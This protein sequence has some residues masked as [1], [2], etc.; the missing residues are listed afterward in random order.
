MGTTA[1]GEAELII[2]SEVLRK[3]R[4]GSAKVKP[5]D[6]WRPSTMKMLKAIADLSKSWI[7]NPRGSENSYRKEKLKT[8][9][10]DG[11]GGSD[12]GFGDS[13]GTVFTSANAGI[14]TPTYG[15]RKT[16]K[17]RQAKEKSGIERLDDFV[18]DNS[19]ERK[20]QKSVVQLLNWLVDT[21]EITINKQFN[22]QTSGE[23]INSQ[24]PRID[25]K[26]GIKEMPNENNPVEF[27]GHSDKQAAISQN[28]ETRRI[29]QLDDEDE[30]D[31]PKDT[32][33]NINLA[34]ESGGLESDA[35]RRG[36]TKDKGRGQVEELDEE[37]ENKD[38]VEELLKEIDNL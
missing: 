13:G 1:G 16:R 37:T 11:D 35:L 15:D 33:I 2:S 24:P 17:K 22:Q 21:P 8:L 26:K 25:W 32:G 38:F 3:S 6:I 7:T 29:K 4:V 10:K 20:M 18:T 30:S 23:T 28:N 36:G 19:P 31:R 14:F 12:G 9:K 5:A 34:W 27:Q